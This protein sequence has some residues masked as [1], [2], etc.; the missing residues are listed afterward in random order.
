MTNFISFNNYLIKNKSKKNDCDTY[1]SK[2]YI[3]DSINT[4]CSSDIAKP[5]DYDKNR[6]YI[7]YQKYMINKNSKSSYQN[8]TYKSKYYKYK[9]KYLKL[10]KQIG[11]N[12]CDG[13]KVVIAESPKVDILFDNFYDN[14]LLVIDKEEVQVPHIFW[15]KIVKMIIDCSYENIIFQY[16][17]AGALTDER[18]E[19]LDLLNDKDFLE[20]KTYNLKYPEPREYNEKQIILKFIEDFYFVFTDDYEDRLMYIL[21]E[22]QDVLNKEGVNNYEPISVLTLW[23]YNPGDI[24]DDCDYYLGNFCT[25]PEMRSKGCGKIL[26]ENTLKNLKGTISLEVD[27]EDPR[28]NIKSHDS[29]VKYYKKFGFEVATDKKNYTLMKK[30]I[31]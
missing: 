30:I 3:T 24:M 31:S 26:F 11:G 28:H 5:I 1:R 22:E 10:K 15:K 17:N 9:N 14:P 6:N 19:S 8:D 25:T 20:K 18:K 29:L 16:K 27:K 12:I 13:K 21:V 23:N 7:F 2:Y 4:R